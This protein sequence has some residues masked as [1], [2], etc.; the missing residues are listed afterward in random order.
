MASGRVS[1][2]TLAKDVA[3]FFQTTEIFFGKQIATVTL[4]VLLGGVAAV[5]VCGDP[6]FRPRLN[7]PDDQKTLR[8]RVRSFEKSRDNKIDGSSK[9]CHDMRVQYLTVLGGKA[10]L[11]Q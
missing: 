1:P 6:S 3:S 8:H 9:L 4:T 5:L 11:F 10:A 7:L 2:A